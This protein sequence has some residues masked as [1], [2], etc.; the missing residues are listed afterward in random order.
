[1]KTNEEILRHH[2]ISEQ[3]EWLDEDS[4]NLNFILDAMTEAQQQ[5]NS[6]DLAD[7]VGQGEQL[8]HCT[9]NDHNARRFFGGEKQCGKRGHPLR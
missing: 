1:M 4:R 3:L 7:V 2:L 9:D 6:V 8:A 5:V